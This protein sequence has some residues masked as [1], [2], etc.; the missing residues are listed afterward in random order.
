VVVQAT[1]R[2]SLAPGF[3]RVNPV[4]IKIKPV[5]TGFL[6][7]KAVETAFRWFSTYNTGL[8]PGANET[9]SRIVQEMKYIPG[10]LAAVLEVKRVLR[11]TWSVTHFFSGKGPYLS[12]VS[13]AWS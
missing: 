5:S 2:L 11:M 9:S 8:K 12:A 13:P 3:S 10:N 6:R 4:V 1:E 7:L